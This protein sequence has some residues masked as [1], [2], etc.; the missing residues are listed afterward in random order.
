MLLRTD[1]R[2]RALCHDRCDMQGS[3][4]RRDRLER[5]RTEVLDRTGRGGRERLPPKSL[6]SALTQGIAEVG[7]L[8]GDAAGGL[9]ERL[10]TLNGRPV[11]VGRPD[12]GPCNALADVLTVGLGR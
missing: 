4:D 8:M 2:M 9:F 7:P 1:A 6:D 10:D 5:I 12:L 11:C 3:T